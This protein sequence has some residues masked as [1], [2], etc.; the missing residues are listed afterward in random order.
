[1]TPSTRCAP[2]DLAIFVAVS[3][4]RFED[5][6]GKI[7]EVLGPA[8]DYFV[9]LAGGVPCWHVR[10]L[11]GVVVTRDGVDS[12][13]VARDCDLRPIR[14]LGVEAAETEVATA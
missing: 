10:T 8:S 11:G 9:K 6:L 13:G 5:N 7:V 2:G 3:R 4:D 14:G 12:V 1:M